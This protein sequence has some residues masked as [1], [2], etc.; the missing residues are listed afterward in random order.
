MTEVPIQR[1]G[2]DVNPLLQV[3]LIKNRLQLSTEHS[4]YSYDDLYINFYRAFQAIELPPTGSQILVLGLGLGSIPFILERHYGKIY[5]YVMVEVDESVIDLASKYSLHRLESPFQIVQADAAVFVQVH[6]AKYELVIVDL[7]V[8][9]VIPS[10]FESQEGTV[11][12]RHLLSDS[13][14]LLYNRLY[15]TGRDKKNTDRF[16]KE[17]FQ[18]T[19]ENA[20]MM[21][22]S[23]NQI[24]VGKL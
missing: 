20:Q 18:D 22:V 11:A 21:P 14:T 6:S 16:Y 7:F 4:I 17:I 9:D 19:F 2:S 12:L 24:I 23:G 8:D 5:K 13:G 3:S 1:S 10:Y 15:L